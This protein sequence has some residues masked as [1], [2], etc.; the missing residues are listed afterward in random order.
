MKKGLNKWVLSKTA[1]VAVQLFS[2]FFPTL[3]TKINPCFLNLAGH[4]NVWNPESKNEFYQNV[5][6]KKQDLFRRQATIKWHGKEEENA[7]L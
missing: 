4:G 6:Q 7:I 2:N 3:Q 1:L 5:T